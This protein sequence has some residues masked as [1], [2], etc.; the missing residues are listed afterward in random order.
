MFLNDRGDLRRELPDKLTVEEQ[1]V[2]VV[3]LGIFPERG[4]K[5]LRGQMSAIDWWK[6]AKVS[7]YVGSIIV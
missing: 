7:R 3:R 5:V 1:P 2:N 6:L 4:A